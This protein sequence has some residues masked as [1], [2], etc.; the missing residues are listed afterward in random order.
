MHRNQYRWGFAAGAKGERRK[1]KGRGK[2]RAECAL[3]WL[4]G[5]R[6]MVVMGIDSS[7]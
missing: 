1:R 2:G 4:L 5:D 7:V 3:P 6:D